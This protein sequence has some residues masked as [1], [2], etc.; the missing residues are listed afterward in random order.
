MI[1]I[2]VPRVGDDR[3]ARRWRSHSP[4]FYPR[5]PCGGRPPRSFCGSSSFYTFL[6][7]SPVWGTTRNRTITR[8]LTMRFLSTSPVWGTTFGNEQKPYIEKFLSTSPVWGTTHQR[9]CRR[10]RCRQFLSTSPVWG[11]T[12]KAAGSGQR[13]A[14]I[15][16]HVPRVGDDRIIHSREMQKRYFYPRPPC[17]GRLYFGA[18]R[19]TAAP[20]FY[21]R[22]PCGGRHQLPF[23]I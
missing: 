5:P 22:P 14:S 8:R 9:R 1:S 12:R 13:A 20:N 17:G 16:I 15:S 6:S 10:S 7:T 2:H 3:P 18:P 19:K 11:T 23:L 21:P 4:H